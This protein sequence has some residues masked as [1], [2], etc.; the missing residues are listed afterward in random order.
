[1]TLKY[2]G[3]KPIISHTSIEFDENKEDKY[4]YLSVVAQL[5]QA[6][7]HDYI[8]D[9]SYVYEKNLFSHDEC[10]YILNKYCK[11]LNTLLTQTNDSAQEDMEH[12]KERARN[13]DMLS[14]QDK[15]VLINNIDIMHDYVMQRA[16]NKNVYYCAVN[17]LA[18]IVQE[19]HIEH[20]TTPYTE[21][22]L[23]VLH[24]LQG[25]LVYKQAPID[26]KLDV[27]EV[28]KQLLVKLQVI[29]ILRDAKPII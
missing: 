13:N 5:I 19:D 3:P 4:V 12:D 1:M 25:T 14:D 17:I 10:L 26:T 11:N 7:D 22:F 16:V 28:D 27:F 9:K 8:D 21:P 24:S 2:V 29:N 23:H 18:D 6:L 20:I 15:E